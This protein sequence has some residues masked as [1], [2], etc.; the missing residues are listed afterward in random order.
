MYCHSLPFSVKN[1]FNFD[2]GELFIVGHRYNKGIFL[3]CTFQSGCCLFQVKG[4]MKSI[5]LYVF[6]SG[7]WENG[8]AGG[9]W[10]GGEGQP[11]IADCWDFWANKLETV[12][13]VFL[14]LLLCLL[15]HLLLCLLLR[16][17][18][19]LSFSH[20]LTIQTTQSPFPCSLALACKNCVNSLNNLLNIIGNL[21]EI[22]KFNIRNHITAATIER[23]FKTK[24]SSCFSAIKTA[25]CDI[26]FS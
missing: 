18:L 21:S 24:C 3:M 11:S 22:L 12:F 9:W 7:G 10:W 8:E 26:Q 20:T 13:W 5:F 2:A 14:R 16:L 1:V 19:S 17:L 6:F 4:S 25:I 15:L 23:E